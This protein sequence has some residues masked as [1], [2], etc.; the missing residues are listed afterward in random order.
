MKLKGYRIK[1]IKIKIVN[2]TQ[3][4]KGISMLYKLIQQLV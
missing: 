3:I 2:K 4:H 1:I